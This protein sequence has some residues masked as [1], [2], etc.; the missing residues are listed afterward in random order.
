MAAAEWL[1][2]TELEG[3]QISEE[4]GQYLKDGSASF[5]QFSELV[6][7]DQ[8]RFVEAAYLSSCSARYVNVVYQR[9][10]SRNNCKHALLAL[11]RQFTHSLPRG[12][13]ALAGWN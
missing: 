1:D 10:G 13:K 12:W 8:S 2:F 5:Y 11:Q 9:K 3:L 4:Y 6:G 7:L